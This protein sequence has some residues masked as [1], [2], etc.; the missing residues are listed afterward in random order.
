MKIR[1]IIAALLVCTTI[2]A[3]VGCNAVEKEAERN[4]SCTFSVSCANLLEKT[5]KLPE[6][7]REFVPSDGWIIKPCEVKFAEN[8]S[9]LD[10]L[11]RLCKENSIQIEYVGTTAIGSAYVEG[12]NQLYEFDAGR[13]SGWI[14]TVNGTF[15]TV[16]A[17][18]CLPGQGDEIRW[19]Y[20][21][22]IGDAFD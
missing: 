17:S 6:A 4:L 12:I 18:S 8:E 7:K 2:A 3:A 11:R 21:C 15:S 20:T 13:E 9:V 16:G 10:I 22:E 14:F 19:I 5:D 1:K